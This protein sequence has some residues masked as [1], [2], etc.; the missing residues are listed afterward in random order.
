MRTIALWLGMA[1]GLAGAPCQSCHEAIAATHNAS[2]HANAMKPWAGSLMAQQVEGKALR[3][4]A[5]FEYGFFEGVFRVKRESEQREM[6]VAWVMGSGRKAQTPLLRL[7]SQWREA[8]LSWYADTGRL[9]LS[10]GHA[11]AAPFDA[12]EGLGV[13]Q[14][15]TSLGRCLGC[16]SSGEAQPGVQCQRCHG[17]AEK[18]ASGAEKPAK[19]APLTAGAQVALC[20]QCHRSPDREYRS[21]TPELED[22]LSVR[23]ATIGFT[24]SACYQ[25][26][27]KF[28]CAS[29]HEPHTQGLRANLNAVCMDCH[30][31]AKKSACPKEKERCVTCHLKQATP[32]PHLTFTDH[33]IRVYAP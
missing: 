10:P 24:A 27:G 13:P 18:H 6:P 32:A 3:D 23:F 15:P 19:A 2:P 4:R 20:A 33:R 29:C 16:H 17:N 30:T 12:E 21:R 9:G 28:S 5:G 7:G 22:P 1:M 31:G 25:P 11:V 8:R 14:T 26:A